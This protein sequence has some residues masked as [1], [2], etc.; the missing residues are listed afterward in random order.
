MTALIRDRYEP[1]EVVGRGGEGTVVRALDHLHGRFVALKIRTSPEGSLREELLREARLLLS[2]APTPRLPLVREDF[3][4]GNDYVI[5]MDWVDGRDLG[6]LLDE[7]GTPGLPPTAVLRHLAQ[8]A[9]ALTYLHHHAPPITHGDVKPSNL[10]VARDGAVVLVDFGLAASDAT[11]VTRRGTLGFIAPEVAAGHPPT[12]ASDVYSLAMTAF[13]LLTGKLPSDGRVRWPASLEADRAKVFERTIALATSTEPG[14]R[15]SSAGEFL[16]QLR[17]GWEADLPSGALTF[18]VTDVEGSTTLWERNADAMSASLVRHDAILTAAVESHHGR[19]IKSMGEGDSTLSVFVGPVDAVRAAV[20]VMEAV[21]RERWPEAMEIRI[22]SAVHT[23]ASELRDGDYIGPTVNRVA[24]IRAEAEGGQVFLSEVTA[25]LVH[26]QLPEGLTLIDL[27]S[28]QL[29]GRPSREHVFA[30]SGPALR[31]PP[32]PDLCPYRGLLSFRTGDRKMFFGRDGAIAEILDRLSESRFLVLVGASGSGKSSL[33]HAGVIPAAESA[34]LGFVSTALITP[35]SDPIGAL[36][37]VPDDPAQLLVVDQFEEA[38]T[39]CSDEMARTRFFDRLLARSSA[40]VISIRADFYGRCAAHAGLAKVVSTDQVLLGP[41]R[42]DEARQA[43]ELPARQ[44]ELRLEPGLVDLV[45]RDAAGEAGA[46][47]LISHALMET[48]ARR[49]GRTLTIAGYHD[50]G[51]VHGAIAHTAEYE[52]AR[53]SSAEQR[54]IK[55]IFLRLTA[56]GD[57]TEDSKRRVGLGELMPD[58][59]DNAQEILE[60]MARA[61]LITID[62]ETVEVAHEALIR[63]WPRL[64]SWLAEDREGLK[65]HRHLTQSSAAWD[66]VARDAGELYRGPRL[67]AAL[68]WAEGEPDLAPLEREFLEASRAAQVKELSD[69]RNRALRLRRMLVAVAAALVV[70]VAAGSLAIVSRSSA[71]SSAILAQ[72]GRLAAQSRLIASKHPDLGLLLGLEAEHMRSSIDTRGALLGALEHAGR[73]AAGL[74]GLNAPPNATVFSPDGSLLATVGVDGATIW[75]VITHRP[76]GPPLRSSQGG[77]QGGDFSPDGRTLALVGQTGK[78][79]YWD[80]ATWKEVSEFSTPDGAWLQSVHFSPNGRVIAVAGREINHVTLLDAATGRVLGKPIAPHEPGSAAGSIAFTPDSKH[81]AMIVDGGNIALW[82]VATQRPD[83]AVLPVGDESI[84]GLAFTPDGRALVVG[85]SRGV[86]TW[87]LTNGHRIGAILSTGAADVT[88][89]AVSRDGRL[90]AAGSLSGTVFVWDAVTGAPFG[91]PLT[92]DTTQVWA[93]AFSPDGTLLASAHDRSA[94][95]WDLSGRQSIGEPIGPVSDVSTGVAFRPGGRQLALGRYDGT[96]GIFDLA[97]RSEIGHVNVGSIVFAVAYSPDGS[98]LAIGSV[99]GKIRLRDATTFA[100]L[101]VLDAG[102]AWIWQVAF[103]PD[104]KLLAVAADPN[105]PRDIFNPDRQGEAQLWDLASRRQVGM[106]LVP[107]RHSILSLAFDR[108]G[109]LLATGSFEG[110]TELWNVESRQPLGHPMDVQDDGAAGVAFAPDG[111]RLASVG[112]ATVRVWD[113]AT[114]TQAIPLLKGHTG[115]VPAVAYDPRGRFLATTTLLGATRLWDPTT[116]FAY[117]DDLDAG[118]KP[119]SLQPSIDLPTLFLP[120]RNAFSSDG[121]YLATGGIDT[122][123]MLWD[124]NLSTWRARA[125]EIAGRNLTRDEWRVYLPP[126]SPF[127]STCAQ[128]PLI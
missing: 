81:I 33:V 12:P 114:Q 28:H 21:K 60:R 39:L 87:N 43:I 79:E 123:A 70:S 99:D 32:S 120:L 1:L 64:R 71:R 117:G 54:I 51:G 10:I 80:V 90:I 72:S 91:S 40:V 115:P 124:M 30:V 73:M 8:A 34:G 88:A 22:R 103:S 17:A 122:L 26:E 56:L 2:L 6:R 112:N 3:F 78:V 97:T 65:V 31:A 58:G 84:S 13:V 109:V 127:R 19:L 18:L 14:K 116:G 7:Q 104:G 25:D 102:P 83:S 111:H 77:W 110:R 29:R 36:A 27:G 106:P 107:Q 57:G 50:V 42:P 125:C 101:G 82:S 5:A 86:S 49:D 52:F 61:R 92:A 11:T 63:E 94:A 62:N 113:V 128:W 85:G 69:A 68:D 44:A 75:S 76:I 45:L 23:G 46:L 35:G 89:I 38:F 98:V 55:R 93:L 20:A 4:D 119:A 100:T 126:G 9:E 24:R 121:R 108:R 53:S 37:S 105:G 47:P 16:E 118:P 74:Q 15:P 59:T 66:R 67:S 48:W 96:V 95:L 41:M